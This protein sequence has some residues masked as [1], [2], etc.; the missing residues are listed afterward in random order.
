MQLLKIKYMSG[1]SFSHDKQCGG[2]LTD[3]KTGI[4]GYPSFVS[5]EMSVSFSQI[6]GGP[7]ARTEASEG[8]TCLRIPP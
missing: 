8:S 4:M 7:K 1:C 2:G 5:E 6:P 3:V